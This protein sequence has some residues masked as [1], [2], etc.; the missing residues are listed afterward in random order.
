MN[1]HIQ[2]NIAQQQR[3]YIARQHNRAHI[4]LQLTNG[5][6]ELIKRPW[7]IAPLLAL[8]AMFALAWHNRGKVALTTTF[9]LIS[10]V[11]M[12]VVAS[13][14]VLFFLIGFVSL[15]VAI[16]TPR[17][18]KWIEAE[19]AHIGVVDRYD[20][21]P[22]LI[23]LQRSK[24]TR[25]VYTL[26]FFSRGISKETWEGKRQEVEDVLNVRWIEDARY[27]G[28]HDDN[29]NYIVLTVASG[30]GTAGRGET[31]YDDEL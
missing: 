25:Q 7:K 15:L 24:E 6:R 1:V 10:A 5:V 2:K 18:A 27:G 21:S 20:F 26:T 4:W 8:V 13:F 30:A 28:K 19:L 22:V 9:P 14:I 17:Q 29:R 31:L 16:G 12:Y 3:A 23:S 11:W